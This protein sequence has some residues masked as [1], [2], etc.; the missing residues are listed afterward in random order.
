M[1]Y[2]VLWAALVAIASPAEAQQQEATPR[3]EP[4][5]ASRDGAVRNPL[6][7]LRLEDLAVTRDRPLFSPTRRPPPP[8][9]E[10]PPPPPPPPPA[11]QKAVAVEPPPFD[12]VGAVIG[13]AYNLVL[14]RNRTTNEV[15]RLREGEEKDGWRVGTVSLRSA[16]LERDGRVEMLAFPTPLAPG[17]PSLALGAP[18]GP[19]IA[20]PGPDNDMPGPATAM[21]MPVNDASAPPP[22][23]APVVDPQLARQMRRL[24]VN[25]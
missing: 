14:V 3:S 25:R 12:L 13:E 8:V 22:P 2:A 7:M 20:G 24:H 6:A 23:P 21:D 15:T 4:P 17:A 9:A 1:N 11:E 19:V 5:A 10:A 18:A 16:S